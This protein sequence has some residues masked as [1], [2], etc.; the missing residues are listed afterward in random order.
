MKSFLVDSCVLL[1]ILTEDPDWFAWSSQ[2][3]AEAADDGL[4]VINPIIYAEISIGFERIEDLEEVLPKDFVL[5]RP[6]PRETTFL[7]GKCF[8]QYRRRGGQR[9]VPLPDFFIGAHAAVEQLPLITRDVARFQTYF[10]K[11]Q[12]IQPPPRKSR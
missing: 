11:L 1:D 5:W 9:I 8:L 3:L 12:L 7:A 4:L 10:P 6:L 2:A